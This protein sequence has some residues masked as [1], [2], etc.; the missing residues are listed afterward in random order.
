MDAFNN[1]MES[2]TGIMKT[3]GPKKPLRFPVP[4]KKISTK[5]L[6]LDQNC[7]NQ[8]ET[9]EIISD[10]LKAGSLYFQRI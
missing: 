9:G 10:H 3:Q 2:Y 5:Y 4:P 7:S 6:L 1:W 8:S